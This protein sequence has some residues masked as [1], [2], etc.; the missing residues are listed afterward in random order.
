VGKIDPDL[1]AAFARRSEVFE[2]LEAAEMIALDEQERALEEWLAAGSPDVDGLSKK[3][4]ELLEAAPLTV[5]LAA[6]KE[7]VSERTVYRWLRSGELEGHRAGRG[8]KIEQAALDRRR[9]ESRKPKSRPEPR[10]RRT[11]RRAQGAA[12]SKR[13]WPA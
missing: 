7:G 2:G 12:P 13:V 8:W 5:R 11:R 1:L 9:I 10:K 4:R 6:M 3:D